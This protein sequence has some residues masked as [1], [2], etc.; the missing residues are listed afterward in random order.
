MYFFITCMS[1]AEGGS[2][3][4]VRHPLG[5]FRHPLKIT[6]PP[7]GRNPENTP[8]LCSFDYPPYYSYIFYIAEISRVQN[9]GRPPGRENRLLDVYNEKPV[10]V[11][12]RVLVPV[13]E[14]PRVSFYIIKSSNYKRRH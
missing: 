10:R 5:D 7:P 3:Q 4:F 11:S 8:L 14:H 12:A 6:L 2:A 13:K 1:N 9:G